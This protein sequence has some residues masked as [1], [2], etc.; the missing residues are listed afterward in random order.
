MGVR[1][2]SLHAHVFCGP[3]EGALHPSHESSEN[4]RRIRCP[5]GYAASPA[6]CKAASRLITRAFANT[7]RGT[8]TFELV[9]TSSPKGA[10]APLHS[11]CIDKHPKC[12]A[13]AS[14]RVVL[15]L[16]C[17]L[18]MMIMALLHQEKR[19]SLPAP[20]RHRAGETAPAGRR[21][22]AEGGNGWPCPGAKFAGL[23]TSGASSGQR[24]AENE[25]MT[26]P[27]APGGERSTAR[28][29]PRRSR[30]LSGRS[31]GR[32]SR[33]GGLHCSIWRPLWRWLWRAV[34]AHNG[35]P[36][37]R[38][39]VEKRLHFVQ[40]AHS[41]AKNNPSPRR[42]SGRRAGDGRR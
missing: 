40:H 23:D 6:S 9:K 27:T 7:D 29:T 16:P 21:R 35:P 25:F 13:S 36:Q 10:V 24:S 3:C 34:G 17:G 5:R 1:L 20:Q 38:K 4:G 42:T 31:C 2:G 19:K 39:A 14:A 30:W 8:S 18:W 41:F 12:S 33:S 11:S 26:E 15:P 28:T 32:T 22:R 37:K